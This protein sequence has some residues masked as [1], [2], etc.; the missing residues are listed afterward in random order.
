MKTNKEIITLLEDNIEM[1][2]IINSNLNKMSGNFKDL[3]NMDQIKMV[4]FEIMNEFGQLKMNKH[5]ELIDDNVETF[6]E[7][8]QYL[9]EYGK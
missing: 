2:E 7:V 9:E 6:N 4:L 8:E 5:Q 3:S 1:I